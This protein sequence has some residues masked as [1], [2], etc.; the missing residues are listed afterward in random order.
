MR[1]FI[2]EKPNLAQVIAQ[3]LGNHEYKEGYIKCGDD[4]VSYCVGHLL[5]IAPPEEYNPA[6]K[7]WRRETLPMKLRPVKQVVNDRTAD[8]FAVLARLIS[9][10]D[11]I[12]HA[13]DPDEEGQLIVDEV[14][15]YCCNTSPVKR[16]LINDLNPETARKA[17]RNMRDNA[18][19]TGLYKRAYARNVADY[20]YGIPVTRA[21]TIAG[22]E[23]GHNEIISVGRVQTP[24]LGM[25]VR[26]YAANQN[27]KESWYWQVQATI[28]GTNMIIPA[29]LVVP[30]DAPVDDKG[31][32]IQ[33]G[34]AQEI[35]ELCRGKNST[36]TGAKVEDKTKAAP[37]PFAL[38]DLQA[39]MSR[40][41][42]F[43]PEKTLKIT[44]DLR[45]KYKAITYNRSDCRYLSTEQFAEAPQTLNAISGT[46]PALSKFFEQT[47]CMKK[48]RAFNDSKITAHTAIIPTAKQIEVNSLTG[49]EQKVYRA[50]VEQYLAQFLPE[51]G[52]K[53]A[54][55]EFDIAG[56]QF[57]KR[58]IRNTV[59][60][61]SAL[62]TDKDESEEQDNGGVFDELAKLNEGDVLECAGVDSQRE[63]TTPPPL[64]TVASLLEDLRRVA[65]YVEDPRIKQLLLDRDEGKDDQEQGGIGTPATRGAI[66]TLLQERGFFFIDKKKVIPSP[67]GL[68]FIQALPPDM[69]ALWH[70]QQKMIE[71]GELDVDSF[72]DE[73][74]K[75]VAFQVENV[76]ISGLK[77]TVYPCE[78]GG[79]Y[80]RRK[81]EKGAFWGCNN[82][83]ECRNAVPDRNGQPDFTAQNFDA[84]CPKC[85]SKMKLNSK[86]CNCSNENCKYVVWGTQFNK[87]LTITQISDLLNKG[88]TRDIKGFK[89]KAGKKFDAVLQLEKDGS[90][91]PVFNNK[92]K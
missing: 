76:D 11:E 63:K 28:T 32:I 81:G 77:I 19:F 23:K 68:S 82:Y 51:K 60:G 80:T 73:L 61:W 6:Y 47:D 21:Y 86:A 57:R 55:A 5:K 78:C 4:V 54:L 39:K 31:R 42:D 46:F 2:A 16:L 53:S 58:A 13:G 35:V 70:E 89:T 71:T 85:G 26:R 88:K 36:V 91:T 14:L 49:D 66:L 34:Y 37:L 20:L 92:R 8:Q 50:I 79:R 59:P 7:A 29:P 18:E 38:L 90:I 25:I 64:Y 33:E 40:L 84:K 12:V 9:Q 27:H 24:I 75:F 30:E 15:Q 44:Q 83:P 65:R 43:S 87:A 56:Y 62:L 48:G 45:E 52:F 69:T 74:E 17:L 72:L 22:R 67:L 10:A 41:Y 1:L 3:A